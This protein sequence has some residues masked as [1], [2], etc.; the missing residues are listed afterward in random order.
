MASV[1]LL[2]EQLCRKL[3]LP[4]TFIEDPTEDNRYSLANPPERSLTLGQVSQAVSE[5]YTDNFRMDVG[6]YEPPTVDHCS[7]EV[8][9]PLRNLIRVIH[10]TMTDHINIRID[11]LN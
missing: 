1:D 8:R 4:K 5:F 2:V 11:A 7:L 10:L 9:N 6:L 3:Q